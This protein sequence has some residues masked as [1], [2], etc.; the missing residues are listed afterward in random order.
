MSAVRYHIRHETRYAYDQPVG[1]SH[2]LL[3]LKPRNLPWQR[4]LTH[5]LDV[6]PAPSLSREF[7]DNFGNRITALHFEAD[8][9]SLSVLSESWVELAPRATVTAEH[10]EQSWESVRDSLRYH[11]QRRMSPETLDAAAFMFEST[12]VR[13]KRS[14]AIWAR[15]CF[16]PG[17]PLVEATDALMH[18]IHSDFTFDP[19]ATDVS[20]PVTEVFSQRRGVCQDFAHVM[21]SCLRSLGLAA[22]YVSG[23]LLTRPPPGKKRLIGA[24]ATHAWVSVYLPGCGWLDFDPTN[25]V[26]PALEHIV[27]GWGR[28]FADVT[29]LRGVL[30]GGGGHTPDISVTVAPEE[31]FNELYADDAL[32]APV[33]MPEAPGAPPGR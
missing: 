32:P 3:R 20:T 12:D 26:Q 13:V 7:I 9:T 18:R 28:D 5:Y 24:D 8:H 33:I 27:I 21:I 17:R 19:E 16:T 25:A 4:C 15:D 23:Y 30:L 2:H 11:A 14:F 1:E 6:Q 29:P 31:D 10:A 22:R